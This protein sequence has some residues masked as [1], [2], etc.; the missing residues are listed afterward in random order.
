M[1]LY[2]KGVVHWTEARTSLLTDKVKLVGPTI[3]CEIE[4]HV[5]SAVIGTDRIGLQ[6]LQHSA[7]WRQRNIMKALRRMSLA[8]LVQ[9]EMRGT[10]SSPC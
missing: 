9:S 1:P 7:L 4:S 8:A 3:N 5:Q 2:L 6:V 10:K